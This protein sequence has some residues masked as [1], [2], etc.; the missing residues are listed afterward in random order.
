MNPYE[1]WRQA[2]WVAGV[3]VIMLLTLVILLALLGLLLAWF[4]AG[5]TG[6][7]PGY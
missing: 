7:S 6:T 4:G 5:Q 1:R 3:T 2:V